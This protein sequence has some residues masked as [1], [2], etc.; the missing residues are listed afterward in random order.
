[1]A[2]FDRESPR[3]DIWQD[4]HESCPISSGTIPACG[5]RKIVPR[6]QA[7]RVLDQP[8]PPGAHSAAIAW[9]YHGR[10]G[11]HRWRIYRALGRDRGKA[12]RSRIAMSCCSRWSRSPLARPVVT[13]GF[14]SHRC[15]WARERSGQIPSRRD[16]NPAPARQRELR[17]DRRLYTCP[18]D[19]VRFA[20]AWRD[21][22]GNRAVPRRGYSGDLALH[23]KWGQDTIA[24]S[25]EELRVEVNSSFYLGGV[26]SRTRAG[27]LIR[28]GWPGACCGSRSISGC[29]STSRRG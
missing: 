19:R 24:L 29:G 27:S 16:A 5:A 12:A 6:R 3:I 8:A 11:H 25:A 10:S 23:R 2:V 26:W 18:S 1:M 15:P 17:R 7:G 14:W 21:L 4:R 28:P 13:G 20:G 22:G 9:G